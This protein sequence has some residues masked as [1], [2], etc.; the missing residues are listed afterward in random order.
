MKTNDVTWSEL[1]L[2]ENGPS[3]FFRIIN[4]QIRGNVDGNKNYKRITD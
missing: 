1:L 4:M 2:Q 3:D